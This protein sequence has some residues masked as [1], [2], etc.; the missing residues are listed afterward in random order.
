M[1]EHVF[2]ELLGSFILFFKKCCFYCALIENLGVFGLSLIKWIDRV[3][4][5]FYVTFEEIIAFWSYS[6]FILL[7][8]FSNENF[9]M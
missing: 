8:L 3:W 4:I 6:M 9:W 2:G 5:E 1:K 7:L